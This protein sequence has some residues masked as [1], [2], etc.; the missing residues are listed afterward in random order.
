[1]SVSRANR[2]RQEQYSDT[3][4]AEEGDVSRANTM[5]SHTS[6][7]GELLAIKRQLSSYKHELSGSSTVFLYQ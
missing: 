7:N 1:M 5:S 4:D 2:S 3:R 6:E